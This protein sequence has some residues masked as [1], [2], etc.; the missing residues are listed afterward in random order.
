MPTLMYDISD[1]VE[2]EYCIAERNE[3]GEVFL[4]GLVLANF[5]KCSFDLQRTFQH[6]I[7]CNCQ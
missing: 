6:D 4:F 7:N 1:I 5:S 3:K 2:L